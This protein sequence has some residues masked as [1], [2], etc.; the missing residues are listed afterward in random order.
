MSK[1]TIYL[2][3]EPADAMPVWFSRIIDGLR[4]SCAKSRLGLRQLMDIAELDALEETPSSV[5][6]VCSQDTWTQHMVHELKARKIMPVLL[7]TIADQFGYH[8]SGVMLDRRTFIEKVVD[9]FIGCGRRKIALT[10]VNPNASN[11]GVKVDCFL[12]VTAQMGLSAGREDIYC[13]D[14]DILS[15]AQ[16]CLDHAGQYDGIICSNDYVA[17]ILLAQAR[18]RKIPVPEQLYVVGLGD[19]LLGRYTEPT[20]T[21]SS[22]N[23]FYEIG[24]Q[25]VTLWHILESTPSLSNILITVGSEIIPRGSTAFSEPMDS[26]STL[27]IS[28]APQISIGAKSQTVRNLENCLRACDALDAQ[29][30]RAILR[31]DSNEQIENELFLAHSSLYYRL[32]KLYQLANVQTRTELEDLFRFYLPNYQTL[33]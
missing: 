30:L 13:I 25:A 24:R 8:V 15:C 11:D 9:Y 3:V 18:A 23:E 12:R 22:H 33:S 17:A 7:G 10:G 26:A 32:K 31:G 6:I 21:T 27:P 5:L 1:Q 14:S 20:L 16:R 29:I 4:K 2:L 28:S 19:T